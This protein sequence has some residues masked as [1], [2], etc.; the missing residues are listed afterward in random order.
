MT[1]ALNLQAPLQARRWLALLEPHPRWGFRISPDL[2]VPRRS[3]GFSFKSNSLGLHGPEDPGAPNVIFGTSFAMSLAVDVG[4]NWFE[5]LG[6]DKGWMNLGLPVGVLQWQK[7]LEDC[8]R[9]RRGTALLIYHP[10]LWPHCQI[11]KRWS[12][13]GA[14]VFKALGW[15]TSW[16][17]CV[18]LTLRAARR[19]W[20]KIRS[21]RWV[22]C[23][24]GDARYNIDCD[25]SYFDPVVQS[26]LFN[27]NLRRLVE[28]LK[29]FQRVIV[30]RTT[31]KQELVPKELK[32]DALRATVDTYDRL[33]ALT[34]EG[35]GR[36]PG[37]EFHWPEGFELIDFHPNDTHWNERGN[38]KFARWISDNLS[39]SGLQS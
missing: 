21:G 6:L 16:V 27:D 12:D 35:M 3:L 30:V 25:Y 22:V 11:Y 32:T 5:R 34:R 31:I 17:A 33:W 10:N 24:V 14:D 28:L 18:K 23:R 39:L 29:G 15:K 37:I 4:A 36:M 13:S 9:G 1:G 26:G 7:M 20:S 38:I 2:A 8:H 19:R